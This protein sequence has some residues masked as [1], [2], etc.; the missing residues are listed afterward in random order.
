MNGMPFLHTKS[1]KITFLAAET[2]ISKSAY[3]IVNE[4]N[5]VNN[6]YMA[7]GFNVDFFH[8]D[9]EFNLNAVREHIRPASLNIFAK[10]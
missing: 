1:S 4:L 3:K 7:G 5:I 2:F 8:G 10:G 9:N 6:M